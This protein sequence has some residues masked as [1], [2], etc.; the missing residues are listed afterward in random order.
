MSKAKTEIEF[1]TEADDYCRGYDYPAVSISKVGVLYFSK[2]A[3]AIIGKPNYVAI[4]RKGD[5][6]YLKMCKEK[7][8][9]ARRYQEGK[10]SIKSPLNAW[11]LLPK[12]RVRGLKL[13]EH[14]EGMFCFSMKGAVDK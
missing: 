4:G 10:V 14:S 12:D 5:L 1:W 6:L 8:D 11:G 3:Q 2:S 13:V 9:G 7:E